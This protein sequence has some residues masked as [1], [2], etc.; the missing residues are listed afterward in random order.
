[1]SKVVVKKLMAGDLP[2]AVRPFFENLK[3]EDARMV[4]LLTALTCYSGLSSRLRAQYYYDHPG[5]VTIPLV[6]LLICGRSGI[7]KSLVNFIVKR[8]MQKQINF[9]FEERRK[10]REYKEQ[11]KRIS[12]GKK[13]KAKVE[14]LGEEPLVAVRFMQKFTLPAAVKYCDFMFRKYGDW[15]P[16][17]LYGSELGSFIENRRGS[18]EFQA[19]ARTAFSADEMYSRDTMYQ[20]GYNAVVN[21]TWSSVIACQEQA[22]DKYINSEG[23]VL[24]DAGRQMLVKLE[25]RL[26][27]DRERISPFTAQEQ[28]TIDA[29]I[30][31]LMAETYTA[32]FRLMPTH[33]VDM[34][35]L[36]KDVK[37]WCD[38]TREQIIK[39]GSRAMDSF[40]VRAAVSAFRLCLVLFHLWG[41]TEESK[42]H[43]RRCFYFFAQFILNGQ[44]EQWGKV[45]EAEMP[46]EDED[47]EKKKPLYER[48]EKR[49]TRADLREMVLKE[50]LG[51][52][53]R[54][55]IYKWLDKRWIY[56][57][58]KDVYEKLY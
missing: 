49:F 58:E 15:M 6:N 30:D 23:V 16:F 36:D 34:Q 46:A 24:G 1:M 8:L 45:Y 19:V 42:K 48:L 5:E 39:S 55:F 22:L 11:A 17:F 10:A 40:Y 2:P 20:D 25:D 12:T 29:M 13:G 4:S 32:D 35:W 52:P 41:E 14:D 50:K 28:Q 37:R 3:A 7:G 57:V 38:Q 31:Q 26:G 21:I 56:E 47:N 18:S 53:A 51:T 9:E 33:W 43:V 27:E 44:M 54:I